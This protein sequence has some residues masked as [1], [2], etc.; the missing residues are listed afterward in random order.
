MGFANR[1]KEKEDG[2][3]D[4]PRA[5]KTMKTTTERT[6]DLSSKRT[7]NLLMNQEAKSRE[8]DMTAMPP[9]TKP[10][11]TSKPG[12]DLAPTLDE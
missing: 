10:I 4:S 3:I 11:E 12:D 5:S 6:R 2:R 8:R 9:K 1:E 7:E